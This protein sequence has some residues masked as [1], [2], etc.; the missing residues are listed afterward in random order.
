MIR[1]RGCRVVFALA[2]AALVG[3]GV[4]SLETIS[5]A[6]GAA[7][8][9]RSSQSACGAHG[10]DAFTLRVV[11][12]VT[13]T[14]ERDSL[15]RAGAPAQAKG[16]T[17][18]EL[19]IRD[20]ARLIKRT[21]KTYV[22][23]PDKYWQWKD[24]GEFLSEPG[25][26][27]QERFDR[28]MA[29]KKAGEDIPMKTVPIEWADFRAPAPRFSYRYGIDPMAPLVGQKWQESRFVIDTARI[30]EA[31]FAQQFVALNPQLTQGLDV[32]QSS[33]AGHDCEMLR[34]RSGD[35]VHETCYAR[36]GEHTVVLH[37]MDSSPRGVYS[38]TAVKIEQGLCVSDQMLAP[39]GRVKLEKVS[40]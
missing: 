21:G 37:G 36:F 13:N 24:D 7:A 8:E 27:S 39:P 5:M 35:R 17:R 31:L 20:E 26:S 9:S 16:H 33:F 4:E 12:D 23:D 3:C 14:H 6:D 29:W 22:K 38:Q 30:N 10:D 32:S 1:Q 15:K 34:R 25:L 19:L 18:S 2:G 40:G 11:Y 28:G